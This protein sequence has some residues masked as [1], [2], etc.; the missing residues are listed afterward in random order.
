MRRAKNLPHRG[1]RPASPTQPD[2]VLADS[3]I[4]HFNRGLMACSD[5]LGKAYLCILIDTVVQDRL[6]ATIVVLLDSLKDKR[7][8]FPNRRQIYSTLANAYLQLSSSLSKCN[9][10]K[11]SGVT[12]LAVPR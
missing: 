11:R 12:V 6:V 5:T 10:S 9:V 3:P 8:A 4:K 7:A 1:Q 2:P